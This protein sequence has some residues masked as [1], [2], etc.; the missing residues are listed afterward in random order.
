MPWKRSSHVKP[1][2]SVTIWNPMSLVWLRGLRITFHQSLNNILA[3]LK[4]K[5]GFQLLPKTLFSS[6]TRGDS[7]CFSPKSSVHRGPCWLPFGPHSCCPERMWRMG[8]SM[9]RP[10]IPLLMKVNGHFKPYTAN[11]RHLGLPIQLSRYSAV[12]SVFAQYRNADVE[13]RR[14]LPWVTDAEHY[15][16]VSN[17][18]RI[19]LNKWMQVILL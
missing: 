9:A 16:T 4:F 13:L 18:W 12:I 5:I 10:P 8:P 2:R 17:S 15:R 11:C 3:P 7:G 6:A 14:A 1:V 19:A